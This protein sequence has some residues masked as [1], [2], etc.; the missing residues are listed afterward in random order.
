MD[1]NDLCPFCDEPLPDNP[2]PDLLQLLA[3]LRATAAPEPRL[4]NPLGLTAPLMTFIN[5]CQMH[6]AE[7]TY[8][9]QG[10]RN[11]WP[12]VID[13]DD[14]R[15]RLRSPRVVKALQEIIKDPH[16]S[17]F[18]VTLYNT[19]KRDGALKVASIRGQLDTFELSHPG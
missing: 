5:L 13:W 14:V 3:D 1:P 10:R 8:V 15:E 19:I 18:F 12:S 17:E 7:S 16:S 11:H 6:R 9:E 4:R 2:S